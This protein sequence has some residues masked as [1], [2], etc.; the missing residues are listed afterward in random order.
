VWFIR[1]HW[2]GSLDSFTA[3]AHCFR[4]MSSIPGACVLCGGAYVKFGRDRDNG[5]RKCECHVPVWLYRD[6]PNGFPYDRSCKFCEIHEY[7]DSHGSYDYSYM[8]G[9]GD[10]ATHAEVGMGNSQFN[11]DHTITTNQ[12]S[13]NSFA[14]PKA[15][16]H[17]VFSKEEIAKKHPS[18]KKCPLTAAQEA[19]RLKTKEKGFKNLEEKNK[20]TWTP[21]AQRQ[22][23]NAEAGPSRAVRPA[24]SANRQVAVTK[25]QSFRPSAEFVFFNY[26]EYKLKA[27]TT[28]VSKRIQ[29]KKGFGPLPTG[30]VPKCMG[31]WVFLDLVFA[32]IAVKKLAIGTDFK[33]AFCVVE[34]NGNEPT[35]AAQVFGLAKSEHIVRNE[36][37][38]IHI[39][40]PKKGKLFSAVE[41]F[42]QTVAGVQ[43]DKDAVNVI[44]TTRLWAQGQGGCEPL[45]V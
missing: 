15:G 12:M 31:D 39:A 2:G 35:S 22:Q 23:E 5:F 4:F 44:V 43:T 24:A 14:C 36:S 38:L 16:C 19:Q 30:T 11:S 42:K 21:A 17:G 34:L 29:G 45:S 32:E 26:P 9:P 40:V 13:N 33:V 1:F 8:H 10:W 6:E 25:V 20:G 37:K 27:D 28:A 3:K 18:T 41:S 7:A